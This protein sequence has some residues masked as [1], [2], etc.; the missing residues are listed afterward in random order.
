[1]SC[2]DLCI[3]ATAFLWRWTLDLFSRKNSKYV[4]YSSKCRRKLLK[5][6][7]RIIRFKL[8]IIL[9]ISDHQL[10]KLHGHNKRMIINNSNFALVNWKCFYVEFDDRVGMELRNIQITLESFGS[11]VIGLN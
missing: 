5:I 11:L 8:N 4:E 2:V 6:L 9:E 3:K 1:V 7:A 10:K